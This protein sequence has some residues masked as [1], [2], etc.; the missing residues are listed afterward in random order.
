[1]K[2]LSR[3][4]PWL[5]PL[6]L[7]G[8]IFFLSDVPDLSSGLGALDLGLRKLAH[9]TEYALLTFL[10]WRVARERLA[11]GPALAVACAIALAYAA[12]DEYHQ[13]FVAGRN[14]TPR[15]IAVDAL[16]V[17]VAVV[18]VMRLRASRWRSP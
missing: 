4:D 12:T 15:D 17:A 5:P 7:M 8:V 11:R 1:M 3:L 10:W 2:A 16:G 18:L 6:A 9:L 13:T 14:G